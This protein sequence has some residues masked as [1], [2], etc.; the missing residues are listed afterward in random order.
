MPA[1]F[2]LALLA[3]LTALAPAAAQDA[4][5]RVGLALSGGGARGLAHVGALQELERMRVPVDLVT[6]TSMGA[7]VGGLWASGLPADSIAAR[8]AAADWAALLDDAPPRASLD[9]RHRAAERRYGLELEVGVADGELRLPGGLVSGQ[10]VG[11]LLRRFLFPVLAVEEFDRLPISFAAVATDYEHGQPV[12]LTRGDPADAIRASMAIPLVFTPV[13]IDDLLLVDGG[14]VNNLPVDVAIDRGAGA[15][16]AVDVT[17]PLETGEEV[18]TFFGALDQLADFIGRA[19][20]DEHRALADVAIVPDL[21][22]FGLFDFEDADTI[23]ARG[24]EAARAAAADLS[25]F[26]VDP[27][28]YAAWRASLRPAPLPARVAA[29]EVRGPGWLDDRRVRGRIDLAPESPLTVDALERAARD[30]YSIGEFER[31]DYDIELREDRAVAVL[32]P[33]APPWGPHS[34]RFGTRLITDS[35]GADLRTGLVT[36]T[37]RA[38]WRRARLT[39]RGG[40]LWV[41]GA[42]GQETG[43]SAR[44]RQPLDW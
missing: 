33:V 38:A 9:Y 16:I 4:R 32:R 27:A 40:E 43:L 28:A 36:F 30:A 5:P 13:R 29:I 34:I 44:L 25:P 37:V 3:T 31:V 39:P 6:G 18:G 20:V 7:I 35:G 10:E 19:G 11:L 23:V 14:L 22:G 21:E 8:I 17:P 41:E 42:A 2:A 26:A 12:V 24:A 1:R 15:T